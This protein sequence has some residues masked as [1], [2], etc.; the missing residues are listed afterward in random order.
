MSTLLES[1]ARVRREVCEL[2]AELTR[3]ELVVWT[4]DKNKATGYVSTPKA[5][6]VPVTASPTASNQ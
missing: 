6:P 3:Y 2:H 5:A 1:V 4:L